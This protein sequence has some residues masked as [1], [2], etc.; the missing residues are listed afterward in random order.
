MRFDISATLDYEINGNQALLLSIEAAQTEGQT[1]LS[2]ALTI[3][4]TPL[5]A[6]N[7]EGSVGQKQWA[8]ATDQHFVAKYQATV[9]VFRPDV[10]LETLTAAPMH[11]LPAEVLTYLRPS[12]FCQS[13]LFTDFV[14]KHFGTL[15]GGAKV[16]A[17]LDWVAREIAYVS[18]SSSGTTTAIDTFVGCE[19]VCR[20]F[21]HLLCS[22]LRAANIPARY[23]SVYG[24]N[25]TPADFHAVV[26]VWLDGAWHLIDPTGMGRASDLV[27]IAIGRD[28]ADVAFMETDQWVQLN[29]LTI[30]VSNSP[31]SGTSDR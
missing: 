19:G 25:V 12:R 2:S 7:G 6:I 4:N 16:A 5:Y 13:D 24:I 30:A 11:A 28:A 17:I 15:E 14:G 21:A 31:S 26:Q 20:D 3:E 23:T 18:G 10:A 9:D 22:L 8:H 1:V 29:S 27:V